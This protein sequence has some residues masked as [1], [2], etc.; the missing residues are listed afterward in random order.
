[1]IGLRLI[2]VYLKVELIGFT[3]VLDV[4]SYANSGT[5]Y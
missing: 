2:W 1:M 4:S 3:D 5:T